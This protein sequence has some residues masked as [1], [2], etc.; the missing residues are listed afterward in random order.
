MTLLAA[1]AV[2][3]FQLLV[4]HIKTPTEFHC[5]ELPHL[6]AARQGNIQKKVLK[7]PEFK[8]LRGRACEELRS[9]LFK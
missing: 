6:K 7:S 8:L 5:E 4:M 3:V 9:A 2:R 1:I